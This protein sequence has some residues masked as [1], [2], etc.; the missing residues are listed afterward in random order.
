M[1][2]F[3]NATSFTDLLTVANTLTDGYLIYALNFSVFVVLFLSSM[4]YG[5]GKALF[6]SSFVTGILML[7]LNIVGL[8]PWFLLVINGAAMAFGIFMLYTSKNEYSG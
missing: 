2:A 8:C 5:K 7:V 6:Y 4:G 1:S 3:E